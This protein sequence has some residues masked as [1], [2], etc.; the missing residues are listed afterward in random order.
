LDHILITGE[1]LTIKK[2]VDFALFNKKIKI[3]EK[4]YEKIKTSREKLEKK[5]KKGE[6]LYGI[7]TEVGA[8]LNLARETNSSAELNLVKSH[9]IALGDFTSKE[10]AKAT[11]L[12][13]INQLS[14]GFS[15]ISLETFNR[16]IEIANKNIYPLIH[17]SGSLGASGDLIPL[18]DLALIITGEGL[19][20]F[21]GKIVKSK[22]ILGEYELKLGDAISLINST[23]YSTASLALSIY[24]F[25]SIL[26]LSCFITSLIMEALKS[27]S[28]PFKIE[29]L[30]VKKHTEQIIVGNYIL[31][32]LEGSKLID[33]DKTNVQDPYSIRCVPQIFSAV[34]S[35]ID[36][37]EYIVMREMNSFSGNP[38]IYK[39]EIYYGGNFHAQLLANAADLLKIS[40]SNMAFLSERKINRLLNP[41]LNKNLP[42]FLA[43][44]GIG[45]MICQYLTAYYVNKIRVLATPSS[46]VSLSTSADQEDFVSMSGNAVNDLEKCIDALRIICSIETLC[47]YEAVKFRGPELLGKGTKL[48]YNLIDEKI[49]ELNN[50]NEKIENI[51]KNFNYFIEELR[52][53]FGSL[54][55]E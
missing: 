1:E 51:Y 5:I 31:K 48:Y 15:S 43:T 55:T 35:N 3:E 44:K 27:N 24:N 4:V 8:L 49:K 36:Y 42:P 34:K 7:T 37:C 29:T 32:I 41:N 40:A 9:A 19:I 12:V 13:L 16:L 39:D 25:K 30:S 50:I 33:S 22:E 26:D 11:L 52:K 23:A 18:S 47:A 53:E 17:K 14:S 28:S 6:K 20:E 45:L 54:F 46:I 2:L 21:E 38:V 10:V